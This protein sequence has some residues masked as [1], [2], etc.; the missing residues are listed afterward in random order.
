MDVQT[1]T[2]IYQNARIINRILN[3]QQLAKQLRVVLE[4]R[5]QLGQLALALEALE[6]HLRVL[7]LNEVTFTSPQKI[8]E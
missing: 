6:N 1:L 4:D 5:E 8:G 2:G 3:S 7:G